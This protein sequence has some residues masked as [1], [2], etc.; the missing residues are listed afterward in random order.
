MKE[1][2]LKSTK[3][4]RSKDLATID[5]IVTE[6][7]EITGYTKADIKIVYTT[8]VSVIYDKIV[9]QGQK[10]CLAGIGTLMPWI[11]P[12]QNRLALYGGRKD[13]ERI[14]APPRKTIKFIIS[15]T[16]SAELKNIRVTKDE[17]D[18]LYED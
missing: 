13:P 12:R 6:V 18:E 2:K 8:I 15:K 3:A 5:S 16:T 7:A 1:R 14:E 9:K 10:V 11:I 17:E 4:R